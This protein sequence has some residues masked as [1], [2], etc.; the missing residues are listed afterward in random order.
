MRMPRDAV[1]FSKD[2]KGVY[3]LMN[4]LPTEWCGSP[5]KDT[6]VVRRRWLLVD[7]DPKRKR[8]VSS[9]AEEKKAARAKM[10]EVDSHLADCGWPTPNFGDSG[11][12]F[13]LLFLIDLP[14]EDGRLVYGVLK[15]LANPF[16]DESVSIDTKVGNA[17]RI[18][19][20]YGTVSR[21]GEH[22]A[23]R[24]HR[25]SGIITIPD[26]LDVVPV[27]LL[28]RL[29]GEGDAQQ[30]ATGQPAPRPTAVAVDRVSYLGLRT[31]S[32]TLALRWSDV[33][34]QANMI[35]VTSPK[36]AHHEGHGQRTIPL[37]GDLRPYLEEAFNPEDEFIITRYRDATQNMRT[38]FNRIVVKAGL[39][40]WSQSVHAM[41]KSRQTELADRY[42][43]HVV[44]GWLGNSQSVAREFY[45]K[46]TDEHHATAV[47][48]DGMR[49]CMPNGLPR[50]GNAPQAVEA[51]NEKTPVLQGFSSNCIVVKKNRI[52]RYWTRTGAGC[53]AGN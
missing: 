39:K 53:H 40:P 34:W 32:E 43:E 48:E 13:H 42:P 7:C 17:S 28:E 36:T 22:T 31:P 8:T 35:N 3:W 18:C 37:F 45:L 11:N 2:A 16:D 38:Q 46:T 19:K 51:K 47:G 44:S 29:A 10:T 20:L 23:E 26:Q 25:L 12:G 41:R 14:G 4:P 52:G 30:E 27:E 50:P 5:A 21:K 9:P 15:V 33:D 1:R 24:P 49:S 6:D